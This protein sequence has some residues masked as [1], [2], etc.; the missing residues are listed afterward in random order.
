L[1]SRALADGLRPGKH[2]PLTGIAKYIQPI[3][4]VCY[5]TILSIGILFFAVPCLVVA[6]TPLRL[7]V[8]ADPIRVGRCWAKHMFTTVLVGCHH[9]FSPTELRITAEG[10]SLDELFERPLP[11]Y[12]DQS[13][14]DLRL[15][16]RILMIANHQ[17]SILGS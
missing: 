16:Q 13:W 1:S 5:L 6:Y 3:I 15:P 11:E 17:A 7:I 4:F 9:F 8:S 2:P 12:H 10:M 14:G